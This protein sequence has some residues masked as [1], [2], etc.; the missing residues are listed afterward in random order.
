MIWSDTLELA[1]VEPEALLSEAR[2]TC[3]AHP[4]RGYWGLPTDAE[5][6]FLWRHGGEAIV[7]RRP[8]RYVSQRIDT[9]FQLAIPIIQIVRSSPRP[10]SGPAHGETPWVVR[11]VALGPV[12]PPRG[13]L[14]LD[15]KRED[16]NAYQLAKLG[17]PSG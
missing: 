5:G 12:A 2:E 14:D 8:G 9:N 10:N 16:W 3:A 13:Y 4:P 15:V 7:P 6:Y 1:D 11:C 17:S